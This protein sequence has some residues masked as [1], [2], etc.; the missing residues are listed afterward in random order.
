MDNIKQQAYKIVSD[1]VGF[2]VTP[3]TTENAKKRIAN[4]YR[5]EW[6]SHDI[7]WAKMTAITHLEQNRLQQVIK[8]K[9]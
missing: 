3:D 1:F 2:Q 4:E 8:L 6:I 7:Y 9:R 5:N